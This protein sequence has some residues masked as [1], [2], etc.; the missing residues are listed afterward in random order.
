M[1][2]LDNFRN[3]P[4]E[5]SY[6]RM[7]PVAYNAPRPI[8]ASAAVV[9]LKNKKEVDAIGKRRI[10][11]QWQEEAWEYYD[12]IGEI[13]YSANLVANVMSRINLYAAFI[14][15]SSSI[16]TKINKVDK[17]PD[18]FVTSVSNLV[19]KLE[20]GDGGSS[21]LLRDAALNMFIVGE[22]W[23]VNEPG[24]ISTGEPDKWRIRSVNEIVQMQGRRKASIAIKPS[25]D[26]KPADYIEL[27][28]RTYISRLWKRH[29]RYSAEADSSMRGLLDIC[30]ELLLLGRSARATAKS[31]LNAGL[32]F[33]PDEL[34]NIS[35]SD[36]NFTDDPDVA[37]LADDMS[38]NFEEEMMDA[39]T[40]PIADES[41]A[42]AVVPLIVRGPKEL[43]EA[44]KF[45]KFERAFDPMLAQRADKIIERILSGLDIPKDVAAGM[46][47]VKYANAIVIEE[48]LYKA[49]IEPMVLS[50][51]DCL[52]IG[53]LRPWLRHEGYPEDLVQ[54]AVV[55]YDPSAITAKPSKAEAAVTLFGVNAISEEALRRANGFS[56]ADKMSN[57]EKLQKMAI[58]QGLVDDQ[59]QQLIVKS[60]LPPEW[61]EKFRQ[62]SLENSDPN[63]AQ[64]L[65]QALTPGAPAAPAAPA[66]D[67][68]SSDTIGQTPTPAAGDQTPPSELMEP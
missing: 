11:N 12:L 56:S 14:D 57:E 9:D 34:S 66:P 29:P 7:A 27:P 62:Q 4:E 2:F 63:S 1:S 68:T 16:P 44:I 49:H 50:V 25:R 36:G 5:P 6:P 61:E 55:W 40:T 15:D 35:Q 45:I 64:A 13:K 3:Q 53:F 39:M 67:A 65:D 46:T 42:S 52:T 28:D 31:R 17:L 22:C 24:R 54:R 23:L 32:L 8:V 58:N 41:S 48:Q 10:A 43:A 47:N 37:E 21:A 60:L 19:Y 38:D 18:D 33:M 51:I 20:S 59:T 26:A 30:D